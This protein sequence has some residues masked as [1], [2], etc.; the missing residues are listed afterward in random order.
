MSFNQG[1]TAGIGRVGRREESGRW[2]PYRQASPPPAR[3]RPGARS[4][5]RDRCL[6]LLSQTTR[7]ESMKRFSST[8]NLALAI[9]AVLS[10]VGPTAAGEQVPFKGSFEG[11]VTV[12]PLAPPFLQVDVEA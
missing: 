8:A 5:R 2:G 1:T 10:L 7:R 4:A 9:V 12:T 11:D 6:S 3:H